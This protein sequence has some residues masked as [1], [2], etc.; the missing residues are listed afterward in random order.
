MAAEFKLLLLFY[1]R[2]VHSFDLVLINCDYCLGENFFPPVK[3]MN[4]LPWY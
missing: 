3:K 4:S 1:A 2:S